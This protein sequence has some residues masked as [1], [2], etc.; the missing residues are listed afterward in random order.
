MTRRKP[1]RQIFLLLFSVFSLL[2]KL[3]LFRTLF[4]YGSAANAIKVLPHGTH[5]EAL[6]H[7]TGSL[8]LA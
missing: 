4:Y 6:H 3:I 5:S 1:S 7:L 2:A 8:Q